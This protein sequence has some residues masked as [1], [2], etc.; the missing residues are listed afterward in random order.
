MIH[1]LQDGATSL[2]AAAQTGREAMVR[3]LLERKADPSA[4]TQ[5]QAT[6]CAALGNLQNC[7]ST[8]PHPPFSRVTTPLN[9]CT[10]TIRRSCN[11]SLSIILYLLD[12][13]EKDQLLICIMI[14]MIMIMIICGCRFSSSD[15]V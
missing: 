6:P 9:L 7:I 11:S 10:L 1:P 2:I 14:I 4:T 13:S 3:L 15:S 8:P 12:K 5:V